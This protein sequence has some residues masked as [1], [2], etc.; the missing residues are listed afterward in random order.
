MGFRFIETDHLRKIVAETDQLTQQ[1]NLSTQ[2][3]PPL[4]VGS[5]QG[6]VMI[7]LFENDLPKEKVKILI[8]EKLV[9]YTNSEGF[10]EAH[11]ETGLHQFHDMEYFMENNPS[12]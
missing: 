8:N 10:I 9:Y 6:T 3:A 5:P 12:H 1:V 11:L 7:F 2:V 4:K